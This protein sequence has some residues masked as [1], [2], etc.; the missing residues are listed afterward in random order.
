MALITRKK[1]PYWYI[2]I[3]PA[4]G[5]PRITCSTKIRHDAPTPQLRAENRRLAEVAEHEQYLKIAKRMHGEPEPKP[6]TTFAAF[7]V[8][9]ETHVTT[10]KRGA[11][12]EKEILKRLVAHFGHRP[13]VEI[14]REAVLEWRTERL[15]DVSASTVNRE[16]DVL[17]HLL[18][19]AAP[20]YIEA[21]P[22]AKLKRLR[23]EKRDIVTLSPADERRL[24]PL[25][26]P[27]DQALVIA[28]LDTLARAGELLALRWA[29]DHGTYLTILNPKSGDP[30]KVPVSSRLRVALDQLK[31][32]R[33]RKR[34][35]FAHRR[36]G[37]DAR[38]WTHSVLQMFESGC[39]RATPPIRY[40]RVRDGLTFHALRHTG[41][42]RMIEAG[43]S[44]R[45]VQAIGGWSDLRMLTRYTHPSDEAMR[46]AVEAVSPGVSRTG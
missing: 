41:A 36:L 21:S 3:R 23:P 26:A 35:I 24:L 8:W 46:A 27:A 30:R 15:K 13:L 20:K 19:A 29:D 31:T 43:V 39:A 2:D 18:A 42:T 25:L 45:I 22:I 10:Q 16:L 4:D 7:A 32:G 11:S 17:K 37:K 12:R 44:L 5:G 28:A 14:D 33:K 40:G 38:T 9:Y 1:S 34:Y 6:I